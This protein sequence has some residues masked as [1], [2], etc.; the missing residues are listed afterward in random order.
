M[1]SI[2]VYLIVLL[3]VTVAFPTADQYGKCF[4]INCKA[5]CEWMKYFAVCEK[6]SFYKDCKAISE[7][8]ISKYGKEKA[9]KMA[10]AKKA[11]YNKYI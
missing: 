11:E 8:I 10:A 3:A 5:D 4:Q 9:S 6:E 2:L 7:S 1:K